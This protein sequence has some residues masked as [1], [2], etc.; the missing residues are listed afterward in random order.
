MRDGFG[1][2]LPEEGWAPC[3]CGVF[4]LKT[5]GDLVGDTFGLL[6]R[7]DGSEDFNVLEG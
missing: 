2:E 5:D 1:N 6:E 7:R 3:R 4:C